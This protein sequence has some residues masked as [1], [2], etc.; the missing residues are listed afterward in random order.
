MACC[1]APGDPKA[2]GPPPARIAV[3]GAAWWSQGW[4]LPQLDRNPDSEVAAIMQRS[5]QPTAA[6]FLNLTL[7]T[8][9][10]LKD[11]YPNAPI[12]SSCEE[13]L[14]DK[15]TMAKVGGMRD[16]STGTTAASRRLTADPAQVTTTTVP[17][18]LE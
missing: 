14:A 3:I 4:H 7:K 9:T 13:L 18:T 2:K 11:I 8:K 12:F 5:E 1:A 6:A 15:E 10:E 16:R 17:A